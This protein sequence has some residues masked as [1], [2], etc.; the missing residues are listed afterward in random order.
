MKSEKTWP[1]ASLLQVLPDEVDCQRLFGSS[2]ITK[3]VAEENIMPISVPRRVTH[4]VLES[5]FTGYSP[6]HMRYAA[7]LAHIV[8]VSV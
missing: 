4:R 3:Y 6:S 1:Q 8:S 7:I 5:Y 2:R